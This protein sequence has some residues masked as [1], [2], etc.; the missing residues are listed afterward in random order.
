MRNTSLFH[1]QTHESI[2][3]DDFIAGLSKGLLVLESFGYDR[4]KLNVTQTAER[5][6]LTRTAARR[7]LKTLKYLGYLDS[8]DTFYWLTHKVLKF[9]GAYLNAAYLPKVAQPMLHNL[10][11]Q[12]NM[13]HTIVI[14]DHH[15]VITIACSHHHSTEKNRVLPYGLHYGNRIAAHTA[16]NGKVILANMQD[17][18]LNTWIEKYPLSRS[19]KYTFT[20]TDAF[21]EHLRDIRDQGWC[22]ANQEHEISFIGVAVPIFNV[23]GQVVAGLNTIARSEQYTAE[24]IHKQFLNPMQDMASQLRRIL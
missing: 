20:N 19:T 9:S 8:D 7:H 10:S 22:M 15:E 4:Q 5:T 1:E 16:S 6:G 12:T 17:E 14:L 3:Y 11:M 24:Q 2:R 18:E 13:D 23:S 21:K